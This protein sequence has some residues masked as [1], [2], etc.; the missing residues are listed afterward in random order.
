MSSLRRNLEDIARAIASMRQDAEQLAAVGSGGEGS[1]L[2]RIA[3]IA[4]RS[5]HLQL[6]VDRADATEAHRAA[7]RDKKANVDAR[8][9]DL[10]QSLRELLCDIAT[11]RKRAKCYNQHKLYNNPETNPAVREALKKH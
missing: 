8:G 2:D 11:G 4:L 9:N 3:I 10:L 7:C 5:Y 6:E 1:V